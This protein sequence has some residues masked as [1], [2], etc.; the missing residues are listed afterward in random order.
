ME[1]IRISPELG[2]GLA[3]LIGIGLIMLALALVFGATCLH[4]TTKML[5]FK[6]R[7][8]SKAFGT[9]LL[10]LF[11][12]SLGTGGV[13]LLNEYAQASAAP[14]W[15]FQLGSVLLAVLGVLFPVLI[16]Q[17]RYRQTFTKSLVAYAVT[18]IL[19][20]AFVVALFLALATLITIVGSSVQPAP[21]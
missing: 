13:Y 19:E 5:K 4:V 14:A 20:I 9:N 8:F 17:H 12:P 7:S 3:A 21:A 10:M 18:G 2:I 1:K 11:V 6:K 16:I 15:P